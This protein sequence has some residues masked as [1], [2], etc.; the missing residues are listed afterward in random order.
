MSDR[1]E[2]I[3]GGDVAALLGISPYDSRWALWARKVGLVPEAEDNIRFRLGRN[4]ASGIARTFEEE[5]GLYV[6]GEE[7]SLV[8]PE[9]AWATGHCDGLAFDGRIAEPSIEYAL[10]GVEIKTDRSFRPWAEPPAHVR[11][12]ALWYAWLTDLP[13]WYVVV[14]FAS[15]AFQVY[16]IDCTDA[17]ADA[18]MEY[19]AV[20]AERFWHDHVL[21]GTPPPPDGSEATTRALSAVYGGGETDP[22]ELDEDLV[23]T[24]AEA[25][26][27]VRADEKA[28]DVIEQRLKAALGD[29]ELGT[30]DGLD[31]VTWRPQ[32]RKG[33]LDEDLLRAGGIDP[34]DYRKPSTTY[35]VLRAV[36]QKK[37]QT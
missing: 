2:R 17:D 19:M 30:V 33:S 9:H 6:A 23:S 14:L 7:M 37:E 35:R 28:L 29:H 1:R 26:A 15:F 36:T 12:Q 8:H 18:D 24:W 11:A 31:A 10:G 21:T 3:G 16:E 20:E 27:L 25:K 5:T 4:L 22:V 13:R 32:S 34:D